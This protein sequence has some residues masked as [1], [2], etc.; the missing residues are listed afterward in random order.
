ML[1]MELDILVRISKGSIVLR[2]VNEECPTGNRLTEEGQ[3]QSCEMTAY[4]LFK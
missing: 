2:Q 3:G 1:S 4:H